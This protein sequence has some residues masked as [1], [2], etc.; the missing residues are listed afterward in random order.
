[1]VAARFVH[2]KQRWAL[3]S[4]R[5]GQGGGGG[6]DD[7]GICIEQLA[8]CLPPLD[9]TPGHFLVGGGGCWP[10]LQSAGVCAGG[11]TGHPEQCPLARMCHEETL[12]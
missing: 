8:T 9:T 4:M 12:P 5:E 6:G 11:M 1:M 3:C 10:P 7:H 2:G